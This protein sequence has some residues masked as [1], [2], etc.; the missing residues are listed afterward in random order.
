MSFEITTASHKN[1]IIKNE[2]YNSTTTV[3]LPNTNIIVT[4]CFSLTT[5]S[6]VKS[7]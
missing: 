2:L 7:N 4:L 5:G 1:Y 6:F 3:D